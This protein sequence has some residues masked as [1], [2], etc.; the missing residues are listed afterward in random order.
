MGIRRMRGL[1]PWYIAGLPYSA[2]I[3]H[4]MTMIT[5]YEELVSLLEQFEQRIKEVMYEEV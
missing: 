1:A 5:S 2:R 3:R 4:E